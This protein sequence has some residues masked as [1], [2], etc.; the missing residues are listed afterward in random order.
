MRDINNSLPM[1]GLSSPTSTHLTT[2]N[3]TYTEGKVVCT[4]HST[5]TVLLPFVIGL[6]VVNLYLITRLNLF[7]RG[8]QGGE[9]ENTNTPTP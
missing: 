4:N 5:T 9:S 2:L 6:L 3:L 8:L 1:T 7:V